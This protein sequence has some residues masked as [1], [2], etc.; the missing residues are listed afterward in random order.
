M[1]IDDHLGSDYM[2]AQYMEGD[3][4]EP[5]GRTV[6]IHE[7]TLEDIKVPNTDKT[8]EQ[9]VVWFMDEK[10]GYILNSS[11]GATLRELFSRETD[12]WIGNEVD[13]WQGMTTFGGKPVKCIV[14]GAKGTMDPGA[15]APF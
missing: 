6:T 10:K 1:N 14:I 9:P 12:N 15:R 2:N 8:E 11:N 4:G 5:T 7:V 13:I 3:A